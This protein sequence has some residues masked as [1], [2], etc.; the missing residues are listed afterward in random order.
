MR[1]RK[2]TRNCFVPICMTLARII[3]PST[4]GRRKVTVQIGHYNA[5][6]HAHARVRARESEK[7]DAAS[8]FFAW[9]KPDKTGRLGVLE[10]KNEM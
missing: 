4:R 8:V 3:K 10:T 1:K 9:H 2:T 7:I 6:A 5:C